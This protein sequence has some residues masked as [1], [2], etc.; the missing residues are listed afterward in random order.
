VVGDTVAEADVVFAAR[1]LVQEAI[2]TYHTANVRLGQVQAPGQQLNGYLR[3]VR[4][5]QL[6]GVKKLD[7]LCPVV[8]GIGKQLSSKLLRRCV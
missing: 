1:G 2:K 7:E 6:E 4:A 3:H 5:L 8:A